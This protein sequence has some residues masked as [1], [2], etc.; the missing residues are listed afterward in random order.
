MAWRMTAAIDD[1]GSRHRQEPIRVAAAVAGAEIDV[2]LEIN[3]AH[4]RS[5]N[6]MPSSLV[7][8]RRL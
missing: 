2:L 4:R 7:V 3:L 6:D 5:R 1:I 8:L